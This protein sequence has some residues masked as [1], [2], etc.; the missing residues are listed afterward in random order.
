MVD[1]NYEKIKVSVIIINYNSYELTKQT[2]NSFVNNADGF[3]YEI[4]IVD[5]S[6]VD[7]SGHRLK[8]DYPGF[9]FIMND[10]NLGFA[11]ANNQALKIAKGNF[12]LFLN[13]DVIFFE[14]V[15]KELVDFIHSSSEKILIAPRL[16]NKDK[17]I[18]KSV[19]SFQSLLLSFNTYFFLYLLRPKSKYFNKYYLMNRGINDVTEVETITGAFMLFRRKDILSLDGFDENFF[20]YGE[21]NDL[22]K[23][24]RDIGGKIIYYPKVSVIHL[25]GGTAKSSWFH[26]MN[27]TISMLRLFEKHYSIIG[28]ILGRLLFFCGNLIRSIISLFLFLISRNKRHLEVARMKFKSLRIIIFAK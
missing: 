12:I 3:T 28:R 22:C 9:S 6:S 1:E 18:Q 2:I 8:E 20:F 10:K 26:E 4:I 25:K 19:Y 13:N 23:R 17:S 14:N 21:D 5:N 11:T 24:F 15:I 16:L 7:N 27:H